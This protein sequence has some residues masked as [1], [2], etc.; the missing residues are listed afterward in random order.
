MGEMSS[1]GRAVRSAGVAFAATVTVAASFAPPA[2]ASDA[3]IT[4]DKDGFYH[5]GSGVSTKTVLIANV[6]LY[7]IRHDMK[8]LPKEKTAQAII[9]ADC[10]KRFSLR[11]LRD[12]EG[13]RMQAAL[14]EGFKLNGFT[15]AAKI[16][17]F[18]VGLKG[19]LKEG[20]GISIA[21]NA[22]KS[23]TTVWVQEGS[24][25]TIVGADFMKAVWA[26]WF[27]KT[28]QESLTKALMANL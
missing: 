12:M 21:F 25:A 17:Q 28:E 6:K 19:D 11:T 22:E 13:D 15:D 3:L 26:I 18:V 23:S 8:C 24:G 4:Q 2:I 20:T 1:L 10:S 16:D 27:G 7:A 9:D 14:R 5:T